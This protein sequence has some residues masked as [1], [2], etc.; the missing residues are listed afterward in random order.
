MRIVSVNH[1]SDVYGASRCLER[2]VTRMV[3][4]GHELLVILPCAGPLKEALDQ[5]GV[6]VRLHPL[7]T[8]VDRNT[9]RTLRDRLALL[10]T[11][12]LS[13]AW[14]MWTIARF[15]ADV[16]HTNG[17]VALSPAFAAK[18]LRRPHV[19]QVR[20]FFL[21]FPR[22]WSRYERIMFRLS[23]AIIAVSQ[24]VRSQFSEKTRSKVWVVYDGLPRDEFE[25]SKVEAEAR[26][27]RRRL[28]L[29]HRLSACVIGRLKWRRKGQEVFIRAAALLKAKYP[30]AVYL[31]VGSAAPGSEDHL[32][33][34]RSL[35]KEL[36][37]A[38]RV[39]FTG[40]IQDPRPVYA[41]VD[42][43]VAASV[44]PEPFGCI[45][46]E[47]MALGTPVI[48]SDAAG[49]AEQILDGETGYLVRP[50]DEHALAAA[51]DTLFANHDLRRDMSRKG[52]ERFL[53]GF[54]LEHSYRAYM[55]VFDAVRRGSAALRSSPE[56]AIAK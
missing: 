34:F 48:G 28:G 18:L 45:V 39:V 42:V 5:L 11:L 40:D 8:I 1:T 17:G 50:G 35:A 31:V 36:G 12:P 6:T 52:R 43:S 22:L 3:R 30:D 55:T 46:M 33:R 25:R 26:A 47:S 23:D 27:L 51:L 9:T 15:R 7:L 32:D 54:E 29:G 16:V 49:I 14:L 44:D 56:G 21:E 13:V 20:E 37:V 10:V 24:A 53:A 38:E 41:S 4:D 19:W 2:L